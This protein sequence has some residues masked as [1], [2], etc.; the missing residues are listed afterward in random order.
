DVHDRLQQR[1]QEPGACL[2][3]IEVRRARPSFIDGAVLDGGREMAEKKRMIRQLD[4]SDAPPLEGDVLRLQGEKGTSPCADA[5]GAYADRGFACTGQQR[6][7][8]EHR[9]RVESKF[10]V[11]DCF[12]PRG[13]APEQLAAPFALRVSENRTSIPESRGGARA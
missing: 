2:E 7:A 8:A 6:R 4:G 10:V 12:D 1:S 13:A 3:R 5:Q 11:V 9:V